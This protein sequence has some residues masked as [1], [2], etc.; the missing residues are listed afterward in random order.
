MKMTVKV[1]VKSESEKKELSKNSD[2]NL[3]TTI[4]GFTSKARDFEDV[5]K[6]EEKAPQK[7]QRDSISS[8][9]DHIPGAN[10]LQRAVLRS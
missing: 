6:L 10:I 5:A 7:T 4:Q 9:I 8:N 2:S 1:K 3:T